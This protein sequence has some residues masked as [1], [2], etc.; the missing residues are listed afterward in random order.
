MNQYAGH[1]G[2]WEGATLVFAVLSSMLFLQ[3]PQ[4]LVEV[5]GP[6]AWQVALVMTG[7]ALLFFLPTAFLARRFPGHGLAAISEE[8]AGW[9]L[10]PLLTLAVSAWLVASA[11][12]TLRNFTE[13]FI[14]AILPGVP[15]SILVLCALLAAWYAAHKGL[16]ALARATQVLLPIIAGGSL[17]VL[18]FSLPRVD[19]SLIYPFWGHG[20]LPT[21][22]GGLYYASMAAEVL[23]LL[24]VGFGFR[25]P[26]NLVQSGMGGILLFGVAAMATVFVLV[27]VL[28]P[29]T[30]A[31]NPFPLFNLA[32]IIYLGRFLQRTEAVL[33]MFWVFSASVR[34]A[35]LLHGAAVSLGGALR[36]PDHRPLLPPIGVIVFTLS[37]LPGDYLTA[38]RLDRDWI[39][40]AG[41]AVMAVPLVLLLLAMIRGKGARGRAA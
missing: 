4:F 1:I 28:G 16:E 27:T 8:A 6:A 29:H 13:T 12:I 15:P 35:C 21:A 23:V 41:L 10:G 17:L 30:A 11:F 39:R 3:Y 18:L 26:K 40:P 38:L 24:V 25:K 5:G 37:L 19:A 20:L 34:L 32:R 31:Q 9:L 33:V 7:I 14:I 36:L 2:T 22:K